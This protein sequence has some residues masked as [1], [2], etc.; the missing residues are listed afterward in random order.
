MVMKRNK[1]IVV[2]LIS[3]LFIGAVVI[4]AFHFIDREDS[5]SLENIEDEMIL[6]EDPVPLPNVEDEVILTE[7]E[8]QLLEDSIIPE[9]LEQMNDIERRNA[10][11][12]LDAMAEIDFVEN[13]AQGQSG[14]GFATRILDLLGVGEIQALEIVSYD[15]GIQESSAKASG[16]G[17]H[18]NSRIVG[19][20]GQIYYMYYNQTWGIGIVR[21]ESEDGEMIYNSALPTLYEGRLCERE[22][23]RG[24]F[25]DCE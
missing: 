19:E 16:V 8:Y 7:E 2:L 22:Y 25:I 14:V 9:S 24:P 6:T 15:N 1:I 10:Y 20:N 4:G 12:I 11:L 23:P 5:V 21:K 18:F 3:V 13:R 17:G